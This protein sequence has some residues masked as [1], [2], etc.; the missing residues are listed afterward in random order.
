MKLRY[1]ILFLG[2]TAGWATQAQDSAP[3]NSDRPGQTFAS[4]TTQDGA[5]LIQA[6]FDW[7]YLKYNNDVYQ[8]PVYV[9]YGA[10]DRLELNAGIT[11]IINNVLAPFPTFE[12][13]LRYHLIEAGKFNT[14]LQG[15]YF[16]ADGFTLGT[17]SSYWMQA[18]ISYDFGP[19]WGAVSSTIAY[20]Y[21]ISEEES[22]IFTNGSDIYMTLNLS[23]PLNDKWSLFVEGAFFITNINQA[24]KVAYQLGAYT[25]ADIGVSYLIQPDLQLDFFTNAPFQFATSNGETVWTNAFF[26]FGAT[27]RVIK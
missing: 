24:N 13:G 3:L 27:W 12:L 8:T 9:R 22:D 6:G 20:V 4:S 25:G 11:P 15:R 26:S 21:A 23:S 19:K 16:S 17:L 7:N 5:L 1:F 14:T 2:L 10:T 18:N